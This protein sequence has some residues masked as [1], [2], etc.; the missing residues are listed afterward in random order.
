M[1]LELREGSLPKI[2]LFLR[3]LMLEIFYGQAQKNL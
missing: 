3:N 2:K 1:N